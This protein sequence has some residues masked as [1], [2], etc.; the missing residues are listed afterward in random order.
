[1]AITFKPVDWLIPNFKCV[2][3]C[4]F[5]GLFAKAVQPL[6]QLPWNLFIAGIRR[7]FMPPFNWYYCT[8]VLC[9]THTQLYRTHA[10]ILTNLIIKCSSGISTFTF[11]SLNKRQRSKEILCFPAQDDNRSKL[12]QVVGSALPRLNCNNQSDYQFIMMYLKNLLFRDQTQVAL[13]EQ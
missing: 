9:R 10:H 8:L 7:A 6:S 2:K 13:P 3:I 5:G 1:M 11:H 12:D 4:M